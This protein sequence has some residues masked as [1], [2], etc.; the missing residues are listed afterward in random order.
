M[1]RLVAHWSASYK[2]VGNNDLKELRLQTCPASESL[3][4]EGDHNMAQRRANE[5]AID[6][7][8]GHTAGEVVT[9]LVAVFGDPRGQELLQSGER[10]RCEHLGLERV[11]LE[12]LQV[13]LSG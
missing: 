3:L 2:E 10:A 7:H 13:P 5:R 6:G 9:R 1:Q 4:Q 11:F 12:L 8:L